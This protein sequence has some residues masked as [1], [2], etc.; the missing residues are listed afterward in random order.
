[1]T[2]R[3]F[4]ALVLYQAKRMFTPMEQR[5]LGVSRMEKL[6]A[7]VAEDIGFNGLTRGWYKF[8][9]FSPEAWN[10]CNEYSNLENLVIPSFNTDEKLS[11]LTAAIKKSLLKFHNIFPKKN[12]EEF[13]EWVYERAPKEYRS[14][15]FS[16]KDFETHLG[17][18]ER[19]L[20]Q[21]K[22]RELGEEY[23]EEI[24]SVTKFYENIRHATDDDVLDQF[25]S[26]MD[27]LE[28]SLLKIKNNVFELTQEKINFLMEMKEAYECLLVLLVPF[29]QTLTGE[30]VELWSEWYDKINV[31]AKKDL[32]NRLNNL[33]EAANSLN[34][35]PT[36][37]ELREDVDRLGR[38]QR[39][40]LRELFNK[41][42]A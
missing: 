36:I 19:S 6:V 32:S 1:M 35:V 3:D 22:A 25:H 11:E 42:G 29:K 30:N 7:F 5:I 28:M 31:K 27:L 15:Y 24:R 21:S 40:S 37:S 23:N 2:E 13:S 9:L 16:K 33:K 17:N 4:S 26:Y 18:F 20:K 41:V 38:G 12:N 8:G 39:E 34:I 14:F 10:I